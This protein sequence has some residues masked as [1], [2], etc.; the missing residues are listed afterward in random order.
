MA[1]NAYEKPVSLF[2][3]FFMIVTTSST[4]AF[5]VYK[6]S[7]RFHT[8]DTPPA[9]IQMTPRKIA[10]FGGTPAPVNVSLLISDF[11]TFDP[12]RN[13]FTFSGI[14]T[15]ECDPEFIQ[16]ETL[17]QFRFQNAE[18][19]E[20]SKPYIQLINARLWVRYDIKVQ[21]KSAMEYRFFP[22]DDHRI[23]ISMV[24]SSLKPN[25][26]SFIAS[27]SD[28]DLKDS[29]IQLLGWHLVKKKVETGYIEAIENSETL[30]KNVADPSVL[31]SADFKR[32]GNR[33]AVTI[34]L[35]L[36]AIFF[37]SLFIFSLSPTSSSI[38]SLATGGVTALLA[39]RF[40]IE[41][42]SPKVGYFMLSDYVFFLFLTTS[43]ITFFFS[44]TL[45]KINYWLK[46]VIVFVL[47]VTVIVVCIYLMF[48]GVNST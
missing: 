23:Y 35:P 28:F 29:S 30:Q 33:Y 45:S 38:I 4:L 7:N 39:Y 13:D 27:I 21:F 34:I 6:V 26:L 15:F 11:S 12:I 37:L 3:Q 20:K 31:F 46:N 41:N 22:F 18:I 47:H 5:C 42:L 36:I 19:Q 14:L 16:V 25:E 43:L 48:F 44:I 24:I 17:D 2:F 9:L 40:V 10:A 1:T 32:L 8:G